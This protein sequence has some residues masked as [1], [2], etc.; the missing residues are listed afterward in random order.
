VAENL[1]VVVVEVTTDE[2]V[3]GDPESLNVQT[4]V[5]LQL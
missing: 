4:E 5:S 3:R 2:G 1:N